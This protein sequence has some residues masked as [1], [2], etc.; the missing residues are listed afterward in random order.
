MVPVLAFNASDAEVHAKKWCS[1][2]L[3]TAS[4]TKTFVSV[5]GE[6]TKMADVPSSVRNDETGYYMFT[7]AAFKALRAMDPN[8]IDA[9]G[10]SLLETFKVLRAGK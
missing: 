7:D 4:A 5:H 8:M 2:D 1:R 3:F 9:Y 6:M 10:V